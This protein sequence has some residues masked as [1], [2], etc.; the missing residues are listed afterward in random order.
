M[1]APVVH[2]VDDEEQRCCQFFLTDALGTVR[3]VVDDSGDVIQ[4]YEFNEHGIPMVG[5]GASSGTFSPKTYQGG[6]S[7]NDDRNDS[8]LYLMGHRHYAAELGRFI[9]RDPIGFRGGLNLFNGAGTNPVTFV[10]PSGL[11]PLGPVGDV[12]QVHLP[13][14]VSPPKGPIYESG[15]LPSGVAGKTG[16]TEDGKLLIILNNKLS[17]KDKF[18]VG[19]NECFHYAHLLINGKEMT[20]DQAIF[21]E[22]ASDIAS[23]LAASIV[24]PDDPRLRAQYERTLQ[25]LKEYGLK[26][27]YYQIQ[28]DAAEDHG[29]DLIRGGGPYEII[30]T[31]PEDVH[32]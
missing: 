4:S 7:V 18:V 21:S 15:K 8:G 31:V 11:L 25:S 27:G 20:F 13:I 28:M 9:S 5:S 17:P 22:G 10:D 32:P 16:F 14:L 29:Y 3:D 24:K 19:A 12:I 6:L 1:G 26:G 2:V 23:F 30:I